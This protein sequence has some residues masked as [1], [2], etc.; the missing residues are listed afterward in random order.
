MKTNLTFFTTRHMLANAS[1]KDPYLQPMVER[2]IGPLVDFVH[3]N[4]GIYV[5][6]SF[7]FTSIYSVVLFSLLLINGV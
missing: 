3:V 4:K 5:D 7:S 1:I 6:G 2:R